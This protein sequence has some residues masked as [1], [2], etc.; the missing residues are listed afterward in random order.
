M[1]TLKTNW[2]TTYLAE[3]Q[4]HSDCRDAVLEP[5]CR[6]IPVAAVHVQIEVTIGANILFL[7]PLNC[8]MTKWISFGINDLDDV[9]EFQWISFHKSLNRIAGP[10]SRKRKV[11]MPSRDHVN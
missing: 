6:I 11:F 9:G 1:V 2:L 7:K 5:E 8:V 10:R 3:H 4:R